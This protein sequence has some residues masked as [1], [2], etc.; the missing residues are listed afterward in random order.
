MVVAGGAGKAWGK[1]NE[2]R[3]KGWWEGGKFG[4]SNVGGGERRW[5]VEERRKEREML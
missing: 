1:G 4:E 2:V 5:E 3:R